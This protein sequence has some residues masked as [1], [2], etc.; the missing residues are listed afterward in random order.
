MI[1]KEKGFGLIQVMVA[2]VVGVIIATG[3]AQMMVNQAK[4]IRTTAVNEQ[5]NSIALLARIAMD[6]QATC[7]K[8]IENFSSKKIPAD[9]SYLTINTLKF[10]SGQT[11]IQV[12]NE[13]KREAYVA[14]MY[15]GNFNVLSS[16]VGSQTIYTA[17]LILD[18][19]KPDVMGA[20]SK[21][22]TIPLQLVADASGNLTSC[23]TTLNSEINKQELC[24]MMGGTFDAANSKCTIQPDPAAI[25]SSLGGFFDG[26]RCNGLAPP[27][28][29]A[30]APTSDILNNSGPINNVQRAPAS[31]PSLSPAPTPSPAQ[32]GTAIYRITNAA[33]AGVGSLTANPTCTSIFWFTDGTGVPAYKPCS[34]SN[35][36][37][38][39]EPET[40]DNTKFN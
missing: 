23:S 8:N 17:E 29:V 22:S 2:M 11:L 34:G 32:Q 15:V 3:L 40:C 26:G 20:Q 35:V 38:Y 1:T 10:N 19:M 14:A 21:R 28:V 37:I 6:N 24:F 30:A 5:A 31:A 18:I 36:P 25:C 16:L 4:T 13:A 27:P 39:N 7:T 12:S 9:K 33:C